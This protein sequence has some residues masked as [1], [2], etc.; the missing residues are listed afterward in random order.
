MSKFKTPK[1]TFVDD[2]GEGP[3]P[4]RDVNQNP[5]SNI[6]SFTDS[7]SDEEESLIKGKTTNAQLDQMPFSIIRDND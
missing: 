1:N 2:L 3:L 4:S 5:H 6:L 7:E